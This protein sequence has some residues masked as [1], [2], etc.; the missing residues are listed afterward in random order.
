MVMSL[1]VTLVGSTG[2]TGSATLQALLHSPSS[3]SFTALS[4][5][6]I[7]TTSSSPSAALSPT[8][9]FLNRQ[10]AD[11]KD[12]IDAKESLVGNGGV[13]VSCLGTTRGT[14]G[15]LA[16][17]KEVD[18]DLNRDLAKRAKQDGASTVGFI[19]SSAQQLLVPS[20]QLTTNM[21]TN[22]YLAMASQD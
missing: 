8:V 16:K 22:K 15:S 1:P 13:Y 12:A 21:M 17:Q 11:L 5:K 20:D 18:L 19:L 6:P 2:L 7:S 9:T 4:R 14:A 3:L 10:L